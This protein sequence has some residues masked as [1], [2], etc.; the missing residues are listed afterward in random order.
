MFSFGSS[1]CICARTGAGTRNGNRHPK[2]WTSGP[3]A[4]PPTESLSKCENNHRGSASQ[5]P[6]KTWPENN[7]MVLSVR[8]RFKRGSEGTWTSSVAHHGHLHDASMPLFTLAPFHS[9]SQYL[10]TP[11]SPKWLYVVPCAWNH[12]PSPPLRR[13]LSTSCSV[14][15]STSQTDVATIS[16]YVNIYHDYGI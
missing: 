10:D 12:H 7:Q 11:D 4:R 8:T 6:Q 16:H 9:L 14:R 3:S 15:R 2:S 13:E 5:S 1:K